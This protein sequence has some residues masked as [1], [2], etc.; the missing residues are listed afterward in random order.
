MGSASTQEVQVLASSLNTFFALRLGILRKSFRVYRKLRDRTTP[1][2][3]IDSNL[4]VSAVYVNA[5][6]PNQQC[7]RLQLTITK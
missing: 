2:E 1:I 4:S 7:H 6:K 3:A 5:Y